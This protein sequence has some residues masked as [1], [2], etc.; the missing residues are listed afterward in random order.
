MQY[1]I[2]SKG[3][4][5]NILKQYISLLIHVNPIVHFKDNNFKIYMTLKIQGQGWREGKRWGSHV[6]HIIQTIYNTFV[7]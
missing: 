6:K 7:S 2:V 3:H 5:S 4:T 1:Q